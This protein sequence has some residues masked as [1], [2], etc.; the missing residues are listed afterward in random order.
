MLAAQIIQFI[1]QS[2][3]YFTACTTVPVEGLSLSIIQ[4][5]WAHRLLDW[6]SGFPGGPRWG[7]FWAWARSGVM[8]ALTCWLYYS[9]GLQE[10][11]GWQWSLSTCMSQKG[12]CHSSFFSFFFWLCHLAHGI[13]VPNQGL[14]LGPR[15][16][17]HGVLTLDPY[18]SFNRKKIMIHYWMNDSE[19]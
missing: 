14:K 8:L 13:L 2:Q 3:L 12:Y 19:Q 1:T 9:S 18:R 17:E 4:P 7:W 10:K 11:Y 6:A 15:Q 5:P 16:W